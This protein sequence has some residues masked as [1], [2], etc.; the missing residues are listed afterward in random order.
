MQK[1]VIR[2]GNVVGLTILIIVFLVSWFIRYPDIIATQIVIT[3]TIPPQKLV[4]KTTGKI[5]A[6]FVN[7]RAIVAKNIN[8]AVIENAANYKDFFL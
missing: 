3:T 5:E 6:I 8:L 7:D 2:W 1:W 4:A